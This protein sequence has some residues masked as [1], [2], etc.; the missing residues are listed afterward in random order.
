MYFNFVVRVVIINQLW[1][2]GGCAA[3]D[4][5]LGGRTWV[6]LGPMLRVGILQHFPKHH[7]GWYVGWVT[8]K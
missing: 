3:V 5:V 8:S 1:W 4:R 2:Y 6:L 7:Q